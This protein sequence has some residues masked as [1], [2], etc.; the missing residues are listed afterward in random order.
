M[1]LHHPCIVQ[2]AFPLLL[3]Q[4]AP[5]KLK[6]TK[7]HSLMSK[8]GPLLLGPEP[9]SK[10]RSRSKLKLDLSL[11]LLQHTVAFSLGLSLLEISMQLFL[12]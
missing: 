3:I 7:T 4:D 12:P 5:Y 8:G 10:P 1:I 2:K 11:P 9:G 6:A